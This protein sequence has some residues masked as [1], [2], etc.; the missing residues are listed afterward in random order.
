MPCTGL[1]LPLN[2]CGRIVGYAKTRDYAVEADVKDATAVLLRL[3]KKRPSIAI[4]SILDSLCACL[5][6]CPVC[7][8]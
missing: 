2:S 4:E 1:F 6:L 5:L 3:I 7:I 8:I